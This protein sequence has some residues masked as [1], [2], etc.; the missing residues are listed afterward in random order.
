MEI[1]KQNTIIEKKRIPDLVNLETYRSLLGELKHL[2]D[3]KQLTKATLKIE[4][5]IPEILV[6]T[7]KLLSAFSNLSFEQY[8]KRLAL[9]SLAAHIDCFLGGTPFYKALHKLAQEVEH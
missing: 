1:D 7:M 5:E 3:K 6:E 8:I 4:L 9:D 2:E